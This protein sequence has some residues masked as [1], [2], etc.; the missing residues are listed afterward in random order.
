V[1][2][3]LNEGLTRFSLARE[4]ARPMSNVAVHDYESGSARAPVPS[5]APDVP[6][7][8]LVA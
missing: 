6:E 7:N 4:A 3:L 5:I 8:R 1:Q 2:I